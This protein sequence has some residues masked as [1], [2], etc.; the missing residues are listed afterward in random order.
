MPKLLSQAF[1]V[2]SEKI[3]E[4]NAKLAS[5][6]KMIP[7]LN[8]AP[9]SDVKSAFTLVIDEI[10]QTADQFDIPTEIL[11]KIDKLASYFQKSY[12]NEKQLVDNSVILCSPSSM[13]SLRQRGGWFH[14]N[15]QCN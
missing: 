4:N 9:H 2:R 6:L 11:E 8:F 5:T 15:N 3:Y 14:S 1:K 12:K 10:C 7:A 13:E